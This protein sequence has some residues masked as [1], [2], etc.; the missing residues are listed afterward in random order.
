MVM[1]F[2]TMCPLFY[3]NAFLTRALSKMSFAQVFLKEIRTS[4][5][6]GRTEVGI[7]RYKDHGT[8]V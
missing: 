4:T 8:G 1:P 7:S 6:I 2:R 5:V 3:S